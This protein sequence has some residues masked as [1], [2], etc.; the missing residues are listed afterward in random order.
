MTRWY[1]RRLVSGRSDSIWDMAGFTMIRRP[2]SMAFVP[3]DSTHWTRSRQGVV[4]RSIYPFILRES[5]FF[6]STD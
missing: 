2:V 6:V 1:G 4:W 3:N 5:I